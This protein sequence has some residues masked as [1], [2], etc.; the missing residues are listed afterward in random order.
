MNKK[1]LCKSSELDLD[2]TLDGGQSFR[3]HKCGEGFN[4]VIKNKSYFIFKKNKKI[5]V[6]SDNL[7]ITDHNMIIN[8]LSLD[9]NLVNLSKNFNNNLY[10]YGLFQDYY[11]LRI[12]K[13]D[14][15]E[16]IIS[17]ITS[18][19]S[20]I[21]K[22]KKNI[23]DLCLNNGKK[24][25][26]NKYDY[27]FPTPKNII[28]F[29]ENNLRKL[30]F[31]F[32]SPYIIDACQKVLEGDIVVNDIYKLNYDE[33]LGQLTKINGVGRKVADC[34]LTYGYHRNDVFA[35]DRWVRRGL[36]NK[37][38]YEDKLQN[39]KLSIIAR[40]FFGNHSSYVQQYI[41]FGEKS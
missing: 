12:L 33:A 8:Y 22:I 17:F 23:N 15:W 9:Y 35:V 6:E 31:G 34:I 3:W 27:S 18:S 38:C 30:G 26:K 25:G 37:L 24:V 16:T 11:G 28:D 36:V 4:G 13:Q 7:N 1:F 14:P 41:F 2:S 32:R 5:F 21:S 29:G 39:E 20:N 40:N 10:L 19:V